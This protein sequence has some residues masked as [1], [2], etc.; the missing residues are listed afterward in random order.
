MSQTAMC[1]GIDCSDGW[2]YLLDKTIAK[3]MKVCPEAEASQIKEKFATLRIYM[4]H[5]NDAA[6]KIVDRAGAKSAKICEV[7]GNPGTGEEKDHWLYTLCK[8]CKKELKKRT[9]S[10]IVGDTAYLFSRGFYSKK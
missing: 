8:A 2:Y 5:S 10:D 1:W 7:C 4:S 3:I 9:Y 6:E